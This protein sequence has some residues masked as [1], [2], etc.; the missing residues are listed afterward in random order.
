[1][2]RFQNVTKHYGRTGMALE[3]IS[4]AFEQGEFAF[5]T[6]R[7]GAG[8]TTLLKLL[9]AAE[10]PTHGDVLL[11]GRSVARLHPSS[12]PWLRR[13]MGIVVQDFHLLPRRSIFENVALPLEVCGV[14]RDEIGPRVN[15]ALARVGLE[16]MGMRTPGEL[17][18]GEQQRVAIA[19]A[20]VNRPSI[21]LADEPTGNLDHYLSSDIMDL[22]VGIC[23]DQGATVLVAT[24]DQEQVARYN[25]REVQLL[26]GRI[27]TDRHPTAP[28]T[29]DLVALKQPGK[30]TE[31]SQG[32]SESEQFP[33][34][35]R[36]AAD[37]EGNE[38]PSS[39]GTQAS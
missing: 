29:G 20:V 32:A 37:S 5:I 36:K 39:S 4:L 16:G 34:S 19:R 14:K 11:E 13:N 23:T 10:H 7:S 21:L 9:Y 28:A 25:F 22:L 24:H 17:S 6:G 33:D 27:K 15:L 38:D 30:E 31:R 8:K 12:I 26:R 35:D 1:M 3:K 2:I 18:G